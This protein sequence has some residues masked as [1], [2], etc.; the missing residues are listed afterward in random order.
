MVCY[1]AILINVSVIFIPAIWVASFVP[2]LLYDRYLMIKEENTRT[3]I[4]LCV[5]FFCLFS[6]PEQLKITI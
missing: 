2:S 4:E 3:Q 1:T 5:F 6:H